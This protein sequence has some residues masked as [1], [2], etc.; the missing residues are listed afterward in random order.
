M[1][2]LLT[3]FAA[4]IT[5]LACCFVTACKDK[6]PLK[7]D[8]N[9]VIITASDSSF[10]FDNKTL[11]EYMDHLQER[12]MLTYT[13][14]NGMVTTLNGKSNTTKSYWM[15]YTSDSEHADQAWGTFEHEG[16]IYGSATVGMEAL[17]I[18]EGCLYIWAYQ[19]F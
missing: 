19:S 1:K 15:L 13:V 4:V 10:D 3:V 8:E 9:T 17:T 18:K 12:K 7:A 6:E 2:K 5:V 14:K 16:A 11:K